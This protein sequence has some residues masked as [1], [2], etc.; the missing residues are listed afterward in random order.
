MLDMYR[1]F[2]KLSPCMSLLESLLSFAGLRIT[3]F[4]DWLRIDKTE[5]EMGE[6]KNRPRVKVVDKDKLLELAENG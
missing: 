3:S 1:D 5:R 2:C 4:S 6:R